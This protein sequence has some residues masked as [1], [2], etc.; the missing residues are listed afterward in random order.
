MLFEVVLV[1]SQ[2]KALA[3]PVGF[4]STHHSNTSVLLPREKAVQTHLVFISSCKVN[5]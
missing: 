2:M 4:P 5:L 1:I 3:I